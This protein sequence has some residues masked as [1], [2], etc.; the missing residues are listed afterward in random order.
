MLDGWYSDH[1]MTLTLSQG[2]NCKLFLK[3]TLA[4]FDG[5]VKLIIT[6]RCMVRL[7]YGTTTTIGMNSLDSDRAFTLPADIVSTSEPCREQECLSVFWSDD[8]K[9]WGPGTMF[10]VGA[11]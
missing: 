9:H 4:E 3:G 8:S 6:C 7:S 5:G 10:L 11:G 1:K 2:L